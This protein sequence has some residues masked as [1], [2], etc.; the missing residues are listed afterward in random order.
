MTPTRCDGGTSGS[1]FTEAAASTFF[2]LNLAVNDPSQSGY[3]METSFGSYHPAGIVI[4]S[5][6]D[7]S[8][9]NLNERID[10][11]TYQNLGGRNDGAVVSLD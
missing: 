7:G 1:E 10:L 9:Q 4:F 6:A 11:T 5:M 3:A 8:I 2:E